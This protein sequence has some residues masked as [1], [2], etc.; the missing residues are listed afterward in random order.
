MRYVPVTVM[1][2]VPDALY[3]EIGG[4]LE[5]NLDWNQ[6]R[7]FTAAIALFLLQNGCR[8]RVVSRFYLNTLFDLAA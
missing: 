5:S 4:F 2:P 8:S 1:V 3:E 6:E 7:F